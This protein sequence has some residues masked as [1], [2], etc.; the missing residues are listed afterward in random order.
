VLHDHEAVSPGSVEGVSKP[1][2]M[3]PH[4]DDNLLVVHGRREVD[5]YT[6]EHGI[7]EHFSVYPDK[8][9]ENGELVFES[10]AMLVWPAGVFHRIVSGENGSASINL[11]VYHDGYSIRSNFTFTISTQKPVIIA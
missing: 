1:W 5:I 9:Y 8:V 3:H 2:Y 11:A 7:V 10:G 4:Q 6:K